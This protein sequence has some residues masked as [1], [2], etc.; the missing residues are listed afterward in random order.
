MLDVNESYSESSTSTTFIE[1][2]SLGNNPLW[3]NFRRQTSLCEDLT[4][5]FTRRATMGRCNALRKA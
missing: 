3:N 4:P 5:R 2:Y 1:D